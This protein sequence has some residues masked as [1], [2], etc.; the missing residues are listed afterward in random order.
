MPLTKEE[1]PL[2]Q[3]RLLSNSPPLCFIRL[4][5]VSTV[6]QPSVT[7]LVVSSAAFKSDGCLPSFPAFVVGSYR[8]ATQCKDLARVF[9]SDVP[10]NVLERAHADTRPWYLQST[11]NLTEIQMEVD[12][13]VRAGTVV[14]L[15]QQ[16]TSHDAVSKWY[17]DVFHIQNTKIFW[18]MRLL[19]RRS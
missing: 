1:A 10:Q 13:S 14:A 4:I 8:R 3:I 16:L 12:G 15:V 7:R 11:H 5:K 6:P 18:K 2:A 9:G 19:P 17:M